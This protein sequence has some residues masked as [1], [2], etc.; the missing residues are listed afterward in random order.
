[1]INDPQGKYFKRI[2]KVMRKNRLRVK[3]EK[4][5]GASDG[6]FFSE[7]GIPVIM[8]KPI[9]SESHVDNEWIDLKSL[10]VFYQI[11]KDF[12]LSLS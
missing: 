11:L 6:R 4:E 9:C 2:Q 7:K 5:H 1:M 3:I 12:V 8:F 10:E